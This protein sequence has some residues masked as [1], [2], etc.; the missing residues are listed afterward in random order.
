MAWQTNKTVAGVWIYRQS[1]SRLNAWALIDGN[2]HEVWGHNREEE[3]AMF[4]LLVN[5][6]IS[7]RP[8]AYDLKGLTA[9]GQFLIAGVSA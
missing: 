4:T 6:R 7:G 3:T 8:I 2:W 9:A 1:G 5:A